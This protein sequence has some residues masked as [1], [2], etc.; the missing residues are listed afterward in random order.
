MSSPRWGAERAGGRLGGDR[1]RDLGVLEGK[2]TVQRPRRRQ[3]A[4]PKS[5]ELCLNA[6]DTHQLDEKEAIAGRARG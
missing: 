3:A 2:G 5:D 4:E 6:R 1:G